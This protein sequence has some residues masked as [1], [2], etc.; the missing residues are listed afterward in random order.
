MSRLDV[1]RCSPLGVASTQFV[2]QRIDETTHL[3]RTLE[4]RCDGGWGHE[5]KPTG[6]DGVGFQ[7]AHGSMCN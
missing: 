7:F 5:L 4:D 1:G 2:R 6:D 3:A